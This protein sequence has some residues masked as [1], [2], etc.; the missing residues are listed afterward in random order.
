M[1][2]THETTNNVLY[3]AIT[4]GNNIQ[5]AYIFLPRGY[6]KVNTVLS[7]WTVVTLKAKVQNIL[8]H[9]CADRKSSITEFI[10]QSMLPGGWCKYRR[11][12]DKGTCHTVRVMSNPTHYIL[13]CKE[14]TVTTSHPV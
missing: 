3:T 8:K 9:K 13:K 1:G 6:D 10:Y 7:V 12:C 11:N 5:H 14:Y 2:I 4:T